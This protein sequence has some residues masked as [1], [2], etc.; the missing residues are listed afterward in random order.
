MR[1]DLARFKCQRY[2]LS[3]WDI[4]AGACMYFRPPRLVCISYLIL[5]L[6]ICAKIWLDDSPFKHITSGQVISASFGKIQAQQAYFLSPVKTTWTPH[7]CRWPER[8][9]MWRAKRAE[10]VRLSVMGPSLYATFAPGNVKHVCTTGRGIKIR[11][12]R[13]LLKCSER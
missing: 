10:N 3:A 9:D 6:Y 1:S 4:C 11:Q 5:Q 7:V 12:M 8:P 2:Y 13:R